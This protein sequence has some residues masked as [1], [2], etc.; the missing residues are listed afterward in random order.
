MDMLAKLE[1]RMA[2]IGVNKRQL[3]IQSGVPYTTVIGFWD[4]GYENMKLSTLRRLAA[5]LQVSIDYLV[6]DE[7]TEPSYGIGQV[8]DTISARE[9]E[10]I[11]AYRKLN[12][13]GQQQLANQAKIMVSMDAYAKRC[14]CIIRINFGAK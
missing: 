14:G 11:N 4:K 2:E 7:V 13:A 3:A 6:R 5:Y 1:R 8:Y 12:D 10:L 9:K